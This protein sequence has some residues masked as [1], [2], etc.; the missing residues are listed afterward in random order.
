VKVVAVLFCRSDTIYK[1]LPDTDLW[2]RSRNAFN[3][4]WND[5]NRVIAHPPCARWGAYA[6]KGGRAVGD[7]GNAFRF[8][9]NTANFFGGVIEHPAKSKAWRHFGIPHPP[10]RG[11]WIPSSRPG[12]WTCHVEQGHYGHAAPKATWLY[13]VG[14]NP[15][16][17]KWGP[18]GATSRIADMS[19]S[20][21]EATPLMFAE[22]LLNMV[23]AS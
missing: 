20:G 11:G 17:L 10:S 8:C 19:K 7:D 3:Y 21:R 22:L 14:T 23:R 2:P 15:P 5:K 4:D 1:D 9:F 12:A 18:S 6:T 13:Y 16:E